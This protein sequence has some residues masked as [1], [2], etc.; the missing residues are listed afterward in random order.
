MDKF[1]RPDPRVLEEASRE[2]AG[3][4]RK[5][6]AMGEVMEDVALLF[7]KGNNDRQGYV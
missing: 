6:F 4:L 3:D 1:P 5:S 7:K 2:L